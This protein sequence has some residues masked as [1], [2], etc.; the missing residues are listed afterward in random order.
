ML[1]FIFLFGSREGTE[2]EW[3]L[4]LFIK[5]WG[6]I[7]EFLIQIKFF[8]ISYKTQNY[9]NYLVNNLKFKKYFW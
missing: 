5:L 3:R 9:I 8:K 1:M 2:F 7:F 6:L 4:W